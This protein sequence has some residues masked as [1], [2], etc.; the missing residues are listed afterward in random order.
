MG[1]TTIGSSRST[2]SIS[3]QRSRG[4]NNDSGNSNVGSPHLEYKNQVLEEDRE[5]E[6]GPRQDSEHRSRN[7]CADLRRGCSGRPP[8]QR[9]FQA[10]QDECVGIEK[11][12]FFSVKSST[13]VLLAW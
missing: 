1:G 9:L 10:L 5:S 12:C 3:S 6:A 4:S 8:S 11:V 7:R 2:S 13:A